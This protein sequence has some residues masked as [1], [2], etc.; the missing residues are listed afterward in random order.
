MTNN[1]G[2]ATNNQG[3]ASKPPQGE[4]DAEYD[5]TTGNVAVRGEKPSPESRARS[6][7]TSH[8][9]GGAIDVDHTHDR[10]S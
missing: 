4:R 7:T 1:S 5:D 8:A 3:G 10:A 6:E 9:V 2:G